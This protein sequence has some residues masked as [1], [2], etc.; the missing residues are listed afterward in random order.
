VDQQ[1][2]QPKRAARGFGLLL[3]ST[4]VA[5]TGQGMVTTAAPLLAASLTRD[6]ILVSAVTAASYAAWL[7][8][9]LPAGALVDRLPR[10]AV[11][12]VTDLSRAVVLA[13]FTALLVSG[14]AG[15]WA[16][17]ATVFMLGVGACFFD[18]A[19]QAAIPAL[20]GR[21]RKALSQANGKLW[22]LD[23]LG[24][25]LAGPPLGA[26]AFGLAAALPF[27]IHTA[28]LLTSG[29]LVLGI[30]G[31]DR[32]PNK[33]PVQEPIGRAIR[34]GVSFLARHR[35]LRA[36]G[37]G[38]A[39]Y[40]FGF[41]LAFAPFVLFAQDRLGV[42]DFGFGLLVASM[43]VGGIAGGWLAPRLNVRWTARRVYAVSL[44]AQALG[45]TLVLVTD[46][47][48]LAALPLALIGV[49]STTVSVVGGSARQMLTPDAM[50]G[51][52]TSGTRLLGIGAAGLGA[53]LG[54]V[55]ADTGGLSAPFATAGIVLALAAL[56]F[57]FPES[58]KPSQATTP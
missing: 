11:L 9:G 38:M 21:D 19:A 16:L 56:P 8:L 46:V 36:L 51:R 44:L 32:E 23:T 42:T 31:I 45:W 26:G 47:A 6:P 3:A 39:A 25:S 53:L 18:P 28:A 22:S 37:L 17:I 58:A 52:M 49:A 43:A 54:G 15:I 1:T 10:R 13:L 2:T 5:V 35:E 12:V 14:H 4:G 40:N 30:R 20:V 34:A 33:T 29:L 57:L 55:V 27:G 50:L 24:R 7:C 48:W 41:N